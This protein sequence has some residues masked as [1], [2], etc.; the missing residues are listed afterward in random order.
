MFSRCATSPRAVRASR[1][2]HRPGLI[3]ALGQG[4]A[5]GLHKLSLK[6]QPTVNN[7]P[8]KIVPLSIRRPRG[9]PVSPGRPPFCGRGRGEAAVGPHQPIRAGGVLSSRSPFSSRMRFFDVRQSN[10]KKCSGRGI[11][12]CCNGNLPALEQKSAPQEPPSPPRRR[13]PRRP[14]PPRSVGCGATRM[15]TAPQVLG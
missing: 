6:R 9:R 2:R 11:R 7:F 14:G 4:P 13:V 1:R 8:V 5:K 12:R 10:K 3:P 15:N